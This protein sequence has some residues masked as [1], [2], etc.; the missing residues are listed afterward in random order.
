MRIMI[1]GAVASGKSTF[2]IE[3]GKQLSIPVVHLDD[4]TGEL[5]EH[6]KDKMTMLIDKEADKKE[7]IIDGNALKR[8]LEH[9]ICRADVIYVFSSNRL[10]ALFRHFKRVIKI[11]FGEEKRVGSKRANLDLMFFVPYVLFKYPKQQK[12]LI[13]LVE[14][15]SKKLIV[16]KNREY[17]KSLAT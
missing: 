1:C 3:L 10:L 12:Q 5:F 7:W 15:Y 11:R 17:L 13:K 8:G 14:S 4:I 2:A 16:I 6:D 9:R